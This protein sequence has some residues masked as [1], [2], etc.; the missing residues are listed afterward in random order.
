M[1]KH[2]LLVYSAFGA[3]VWNA[4]ASV[5]GPGD[6]LIF[7]IDTSGYFANA[8]R[9]GAP[10]LPSHVDLTFVS[11][12]IADSSFSARLQS[13][14][15]T[16]SVSFPAL[17]SFQPGYFQGSGYS[18][19]ASTIYGGLSLP[20]ATSSALFRDPKLFLYLQNAGDAVEIGLPPYGL[21]QD[22]TLSLTGGGL[23]VGARVSG[24]PNFV[25]QAPEPATNLMLLGGGAGLCLASFVT[26][27][28]RRIQMRGAVGRQHTED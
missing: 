3:F 19:P 13:A 17:L 12:P 7:Q 25:S 18:G 10:L 4:N 28:F 27:R 14:D 6:E 5:L 2:W 24:A 26:K 1:V 20:A 22:L 21:S 8:L 23:S 15:G 16:V 9:Y 11:A